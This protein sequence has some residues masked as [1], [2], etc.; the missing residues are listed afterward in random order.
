MGST[1]INATTRTRAWVHNQIYMS[2]NNGKRCNQSFY[3][4]ACTHSQRSK[5]SINDW[6][7]WK[8]YPG[9][10]EDISLQLCKVNVTRT[11]TRM[12]RQSK[13]I[14][15]YFLVCLPSRLWVLL[16]LFL[17]SIWSNSCSGAC[18][19]VH[20]QLNLIPKTLSHPN[21]DHT[22]PLFPTS[23]PNS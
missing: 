12:R 11:R 1:R 22:L 20:L 5:P 8:G 7:K 16:C 6:F 18:S 9:V 10:S 4:H 13:T 14:H 2:K 23:C 15:Q 17:A 19:N 3:G 21:L